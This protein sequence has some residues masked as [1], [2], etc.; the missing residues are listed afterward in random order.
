MRGRSRPPRTFRLIIL[1]EA[2]EDA[3]SSPFTAERPAVYSRWAQ[4]TSVDRPAAPTSPE[5]GMG[6]CPM[7]F[8]GGPSPHERKPQKPPEDWALNTDDFD[9]GELRELLE[10]DK[11]PPEDAPPASGCPF[12]FG[13][14]GAPTAESQEEG[15]GEAIGASACPFSGAMG[16]SGGM[17]PVGFGG[18]PDDDGE[19]SAPGPFEG[20]Q[21]SARIPRIAALFP[22]LEAG[23]AAGGRPFPR[24]R[25]DR[26]A[27]PPPPRTSPRRPGS[28]GGEGRQALRDGP[29]RDHRRGDENVRGQGPRPLPG[30]PGQ[31]RHDGLQRRR[32]VRR[33]GQ[34]PP[35]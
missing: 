18:V 23:S 30:G 7:G 31:L 27:G 20:V 19:L 34:E 6:K 22:S 1:H 12:G 9:E 24:A 13:G 32:A 33:D 3:Q 28:A 5:I 21:V 17:C 8:V 4:P 10:R 2:V 26:D 11:S 14:G 29:H 16:A 35:R 25:P 15:G